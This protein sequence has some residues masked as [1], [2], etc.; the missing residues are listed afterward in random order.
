MRNDER[1]SMN[2]KRT[3]P[4][5]AQRSPSQGHTRRQ[6]AWDTKNG[7]AALPYSSNSQLLTP[8]SSRQRSAGPQASRLPCR[9]DVGGPC[10]PDARPPVTCHLSPVTS[11]PRRAAFSLIE[12]LVVISIIAI[13]MAILLPALSKILSEAHGTATQEEMSAISSACL[14]YEATFNAYPGPFSE[15]DISQQKVTYTGYGPDGNGLASQAQPITGTQNMLIGLMGTMYNAQP[16]SGLPNS[17]IL[18]SGADY[19]MVSDSVGA[20][21]NGGTGYFVS[22]PLGSGPIDYAN[23]GVQKASFFNPQAVD[24]LPEPPSLAT[25]AAIVAPGGVVMPTPWL[26]TLYD[27][28]PDGLPILYY[29]KNP[30]MPGATGVPVWLNAGNAGGAAGTGAAYYLGDN[31]LYTDS[32][33]PPPPPP[34]VPGD[35]LDSKTG[36]TY[37]QDNGTIL[38]SCYYSKAT[39]P[40]TPEEALANTLINQSL[41][42]SAYTGPLTANTQGFPVQGDFA[43]ISAGADHI[44]GFNNYS[45]GVLVSA[46]PPI[47]TSDDIVV[48]GG[49]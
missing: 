10:G 41:A 12:L 26:P 9:Q 23:G 28:F 4:Q 35:T 6:D 37:N 1:I 29:R 49:Q 14:S 19:V 46:G 17:P 40:F 42:G 36:T 38:Q 30:G 20:D 15:A 27:A 39:G 2:D 43:L 21:N 11:S 8:D 24:L 45:N 34:A 48:F 31:L 44:Y 18:P 47:P 22:N 32:T 25:S 13:L 33:T 5:R 3:E 16:N 7:S